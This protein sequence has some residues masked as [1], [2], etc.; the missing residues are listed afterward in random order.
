MCQSAKSAV[1]RTSLVK[2]WAADMHA[3]MSALGSQGKHGKG[4]LPSG[5]R[6]VWA[7]AWGACPFVKL[8]GARA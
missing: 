5:R 7:Q 4:L 6:R 2:G 1:C 3:E 8:T